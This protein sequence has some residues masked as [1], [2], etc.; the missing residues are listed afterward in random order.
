MNVTS[1]EYLEYPTE[2]IIFIVSLSYKLK[3]CSLVHFSK[4]KKLK[5][6][7]RSQF[8]FRNAG[9]P[10]VCFFRMY[11]YNRNII[12]DS[13]NIWRRKETLSFPWWLW[14]EYK[15][16]SKQR[17][18]NPKPLF[19]LQF[20]FVSTKR[21]Y[22]VE[23]NALF[24]YTKSLIIIPIQ[25]GK[26][27]FSM[28]YIVSRVEYKGYRDLQTGVFEVSIRISVGNKQEIYFDRTI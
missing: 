4:K 19:S 13:K 12:P 11:F 22:Y 3:Q 21:C 8:S 17:K 6:Y 26:D 23:T 20:E 9:K 24:I 10:N 7:H 16:I 14:K 18:T 1:V 28:L 15:K 25:H 27:T 5:P 2:L